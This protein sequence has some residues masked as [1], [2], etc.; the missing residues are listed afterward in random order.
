MRNGWIDD[1]GFGFFVYGGLGW[2]V[3]NGGGGG[4][5]SRWLIIRRKFH[6]MV[7]YLGS[8]F[9]FIYIDY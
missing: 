8:L 1:D 9:I 3:M 5:L 6:G 2:L 4:L 7:I